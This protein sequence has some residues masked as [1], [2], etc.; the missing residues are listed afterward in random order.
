MTNFYCNG[1]DGLTT[2]Y[3]AIQPWKRA[4]SYVN[5]SYVRQRGGQITIGIA[6]DF[7]AGKMWFKDLTNNGQWNDS[8]TDDP[9]TTTGGISNTVT[10]A[11]YP[12]VTSTN[13][14]VLTANFGATSF[15]GSVPS[16][17][18]DV[19]TANGSAVT[20][21]SGNK[22]V[23]L[24]LAGGNL[25]AQGDFD[26]GAFNT[27]YS[28]RATASFNSGKIYWEV[29][30]GWGTSGSLMR[31]TFNP[32]WVVGAVN[33]T[34]GITGGTGVSADG[35]SWGWVASVGQIWKS[36]SNI[37]AVHI[38]N[39]VAT[40]NERVFKNNGST[41][42]SGATQP[43]WNLG[44]N[45]TTSDNGGT[46]TE[47]TGKAAE[48][49]N[50]CFAR[51][52]SAQSRMAVSGDVCFVG[53]NHRQGMGNGS[54]SLG[55]S[56]NN[57]YYNFLSVDH[58]VSS[59]GSG[60][61][62][63]GASISLYG[64]TSNITGNFHLNGVT[65]AGVGVGLCVPT[66]GS[67]QDNAQRYDNCTFTTSGG[68]GPFIAGGGTK[69]LYLEFNNCTFSASNSTQILRPGGGKSVFKGGSIS[70]VSSNSVFGGESGTV[71]AT[72]IFEGVDMSGVAGVF[73]NTSQNSCVQFY[74]S[75]CKIPSATFFQNSASQN[76]GY[77]EIYFYACDT[78]TD[79]EAHGKQHHAGFQQDSKTVIRTGGTSDGVNGYSEKVITT[80]N[81]SWQFPFVSLPMDV[82]NDTTGANRTITIYGIVNAAAVPTTAEIWPELRYLGSA[83]SLISSLATGGIANVLA[84]GS[85]WIAD[86]TSAWDSNVTART[87]GETVAVGAIRKVASNPGRVFFC[88]SIGTGVL[89]GS[90][91][92]G[93][94][95]AVDGGVVTDGGA[96]F[97]A[98]YRFSMAVT[99]TSPLPQPQLAGL[100][101]VI[102][103]IAKTSTT[104][105]ID[106]IQAAS[107]T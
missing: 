22:A 3:W 79:Q 66:I 48:G 27:N 7:G 104:Y 69:D 53:D 95:S 65:I 100:I 25:V 10:A 39:A 41:I 23:R 60:D 36:G 28:V 87:N 50:A 30:C 19:N 4:T 102:V 54:F 31:T 15:V 6:V 94:A 77:P 42:T 57:T 16:G 81:A 64:F 92:A 18:S 49:W 38:I 9:G 68:T 40:G 35:N 51:M 75:R 90:L 8:G 97:R 86:T 91:P 72:M 34:F 59:P 21:D 82:W 71:G 105:Y 103:K 70:T 29:T 93:Y 101:S 107:L 1:G 62:L 61:L 14:A 52:D 12:A 84:S 44:N 98:G 56:S 2:G 67:T 80:S 78:G 43:S 74:V 33:S 47:V 63:A 83:S 58:T 73:I 89:S 45:A 96:T 99:I 13:G 46:W 20:W 76:P 26:N 5:G 17:F 24:L 85:N 11:L 106:A 32:D 88:T 37:G 55:N